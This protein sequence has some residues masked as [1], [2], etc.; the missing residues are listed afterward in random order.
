VLQAH[1]QAGGGAVLTTHIDLELSVESLDLTS[2][3]ATAQSPS[4]AFEEALE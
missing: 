1:L 3:I 4:S 2:Y